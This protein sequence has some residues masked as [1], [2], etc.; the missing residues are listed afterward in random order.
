M[1]GPRDASSATHRV[2]PQLSEVEVNSRVLQ[3]A[4]ERRKKVVMVI[5][6]RDEGE[7]IKQ[8]VEQMITLLHEQTNYDFKIVIAEEGSKDYTYATAEQLERKHP[9]IVKVLHRD[10]RIG[11]G[12]SVKEAWLSEDADIYCYADADLPFDDHDIFNVIKAIEE[13]K[14]DIATG[15]R[16]MRDSSTI[17]P[18][19][20][21]F[22]SFV[23]NKLVQLMTASK[24]RDH[25][26]GLKAVNRT[27]VN[28]VVLRSKERHWSWD[29]EI[30]VLSQLS[31]FRVQ[32]VPI[33]WVE[34]RH[35]RTPIMR[36]IKD[37]IEHSHWLF[38]F[39][40][41]VKSILSKN[42]EL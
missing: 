42:G 9:K 28:D 27:I 8:V 20:R 6:A 40:S 2:N 12:Y 16:Y 29:S 5:P 18:V 34:S 22:V 14:C 19:L 30:L 23:Y 31:G 15:S 39:P 17:R 36:T 10:H 38:S 24:I 32:E 3:V 35:K 4:I 33:T 7:R 37:I 13:D 26:C 41:R 1:L 21:L 11:R 25:Q